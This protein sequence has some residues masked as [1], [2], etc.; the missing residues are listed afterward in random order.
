MIKHRLSLNLGRSICMVLILLFLQSTFLAFSTVRA[1]SLD[2]DDDDNQP[3]RGNI[4][5]RG[6]FTSTLQSPPVLRST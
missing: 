3:R 2:D 6:C 4:Q 1:A 5:A